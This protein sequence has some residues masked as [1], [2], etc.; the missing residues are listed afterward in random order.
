MGILQRYVFIELLRVFLMLVF[1]LTGVLVLVGV[2]S[3]A[4]A[5]GL[6]PLQI[7]EILPYIVPSLLPFT[8]PATAL[9]TACVVFGRMAGDQEIT[10][11]KAAGINVLSVL[12]P[13]FSLGAILSLCTL[14][15]TDQFVPWARSQIERAITLAMEDIFF[16]MLR[17]RN[18]FSNLEKTLVITAMRVDGKKL[19]QPTFRY[20][21][22][23]GGTVTIQADEATVRF[24]LRNREV[25]LRLVHG[26]VET[27]GSGTVWFEE[28][29]QAFPLP[30]KTEATPVR[31]LTLRNLREQ[32]EEI[33]QDS[34]A[35][36]ERQVLSSVF[37]L[38]RGDFA[39]VQSE[40]LKLYDQKQKQAWG[41]H[42]RLNTE[43]HNR[44]AMSCSCF[45]FVLLGAPFSVLQGRRQFLTNFFLCFLPVL[46]LYYPVMM[47][48]MTLAKE[49]RVNPAWGMW[50]ANGLLLLLALDVLRKVLKN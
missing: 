19:I 14:L 50:V 27:S 41:R 3:E 4:S 26:H 13:A 11:V 42:A 33:K 16:D 25:I 8:I 32:L 43:Y 17:S 6:G 12:W 46:L 9:L 22:E 1:V 38:N 44:I 47:L 37:A 23:G 28:Q 29:E 39:Q 15:L 48:M 40:T 21:Q 34:Q 24:D 35:L 49:Q 31:S 18:A 10:A 36:E 45:I 2:V 30:T 5:N 7:L 20:T